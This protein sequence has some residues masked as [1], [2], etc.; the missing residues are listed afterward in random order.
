[1]SNDH[2]ATFDRLRA[3]ALNAAILN[4]TDMSACD[5]NPDVQPQRD[6]KDEVRRA[7][8][9]DI[10]TGLRTG[11]SAFTRLLRGRRRAALN[12]LARVPSASL[13]GGTRHTP[14]RGGR[15]RRRTL[16]RMHA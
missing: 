15:M 5:S 8:S 2:A 12:P 10:A 4:A 3:R 13:A 11:V 7:L 16:P 9:T 6:R 14:G 1:M